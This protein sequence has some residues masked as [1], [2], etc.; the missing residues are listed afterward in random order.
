MIVEVMQRIEKA[1]PLATRL[2]TCSVGD[3]PTETRQN[4]ISEGGPSI[5][6]KA[7]RPYLA[8]RGPLK[9]QSAYRRTLLVKRGFSRMEPRMVSSRHRKG[10]G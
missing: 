7:S 10:E 5:A 4:P 3:D 2:T 8:C 1:E 6:L 9:S